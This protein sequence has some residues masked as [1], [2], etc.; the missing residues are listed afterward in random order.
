MEEELK[1][2]TQKTKK[3]VESINEKQ[4]QIRKLHEAYIIKE[5]K[6]KEIENKL[7]EKKPNQEEIN[8]H[9]ISQLEEEV[10]QLEAQRAEV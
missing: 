6:V 5:E 9:V 3:Q 8:E 7:K 10:K 4:K 2:L 1:Q